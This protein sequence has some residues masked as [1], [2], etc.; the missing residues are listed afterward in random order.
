M[1][2]KEFYSN[3]WEAVD[4]AGTSF[5]PAAKLFPLT[6]GMSVRLE[7]LI[8][9]CMFVCVCVCQHLHIKSCSFILMCTQIQHEQLVCL[10]VDKAPITSLYHLHP[11]ITSLA[12]HPAFPVH[13]ACATLA[14]LPVLLTCILFPLHYF[15]TSSVSMLCVP[16]SLIV[17]VS[18]FSVHANKHSSQ[19]RRRFCTLTL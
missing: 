7:V 8:C 18:F 5:V 15:P 2:C 14:T 11:Y 9:V 1:E 13:V 3:R 19:H 4:P 17:L 16:A 10:T 12:P 6:A